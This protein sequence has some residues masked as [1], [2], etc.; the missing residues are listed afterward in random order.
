ML[1]DY[2]R[3][4]LAALISRF[5]RSVCEDSRRCEALL[6]DM[7]PDFKRETHLLVVAIKERVVADLLL[8][9]A[10]PIELQIQQLA[11]RLH[12]NLG[13]AEN[14]ALWTVESWALALDIIDKPMQQ[15][16]FQDSEKS[17]ELRKISQADTKASSLSQ[18]SASFSKLLAFLPKKKTTVTSTV[19][20]VPIR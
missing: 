16:S 20:V 8:P 17:L 14:F 5:G 3:Q 11:Q 7:C 6:K 2:P 15:L 1:N 4:Q 18:M 12:D 10:L 9:T 13:I 19:P